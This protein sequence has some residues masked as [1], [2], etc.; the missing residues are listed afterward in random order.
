MSFIFT[1]FQIHFWAAEISLKLD[2]VLSYVHERERSHSTIAIEI[3]QLSC[4]CCV[5]ARARERSIQTNRI[6]SVW[7]GHI[8]TY[9]KKIIISG[10]L[11]IQNHI[12]SLFKS[13]FAT[14]YIS[15]CKL[16]L[17]L[18]DF[19]ATKQIFVLDFCVCNVQTNKINKCGAALWPRILCQYGSSINRWQIDFHILC[20]WFHSVVFPKTEFYSIYIWFVNWNAVHI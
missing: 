8:Y 9:N 4:D 17:F 1:S 19:Y 3:F 13:S 5:Y 16:V 12:I 15:F 7:H 14:Q 11:L 6:H 18:V 20:H 10:V 2:H